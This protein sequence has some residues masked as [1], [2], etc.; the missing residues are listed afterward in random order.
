[1][2]PAHDAVTFSSVLNLSA[3]P[4]RAPSTLFLLTCGLRRYA[5]PTRHRQPG[6]FSWVS[7]DLGVSVVGSFTVNGDGDGGEIKTNGGTPRLLLN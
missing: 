2:Q 3:S 1:M 4:I 7:V 5:G 6:Y